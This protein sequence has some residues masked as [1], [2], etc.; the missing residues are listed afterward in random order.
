MRQKWTAR[1]NQSRFLRPKAGRYA[2]CGRPLYLVERRVCLLPK[3]EVQE[4]MIALRIAM[5]FTLAAFLLSLHLIC[6]AWYFW[7]VLLR[8]SHCAW[9]WKSF[10]LMQ[11]YPRSWSS[12]ICNHHDLQLRAQSAVRRARRLAESA[13]T[14][15]EVQ[16]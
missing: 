13:R 10:R 8:K 11:W 2:L 7:P 15:A 5:C 14:Q 6:F 3:E 12:S 16:A 9:C 1:I 4:D